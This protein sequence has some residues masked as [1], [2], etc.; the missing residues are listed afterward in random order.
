MYHPTKALV[1]TAIKYGENSRVLRCFTRQFGLQTYLVNSVSR[2]KGVIRSA[3]ILPLS[4]LDLVVT[5]KAKGTLER[6][7]EARVYVPYMALH[8]D[9][10]RNALALFMAELLS[11]SLKEEGPDEAKFDFIAQQCAA[12]DQLPRVPAHFHLSFMLA[13]MR[14]LGFYPDQNIPVQDCYFDM[15]EGNFTTM[16]PLHPYYMDQ[17]T[18]ASLAQLIENNADLKLPKQNR[19]HLLDGLLQYYRIH[20]QEFGELKSVEILSELFSD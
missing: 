18:T 11:R 5:H 3:M 16:K 20:N 17:P 15:I 19:K 7:K 1:L 13:L 4:Q 14:Y 12:L 2:K 10:V 8:T 6:I 9:P